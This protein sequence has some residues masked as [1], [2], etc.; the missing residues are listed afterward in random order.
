GVGDGARRQ[1]AAAQ[2]V[3]GRQRV[4]SP[5][6]LVLALLP[7]VAGCRRAPNG[8]AG[9]AP[10]PVR[11]V[12]VFQQAGIH[13]RHTN[14]QSARAFTAE[15]LGS[16]CAFLDYDGDGRLDLFLV[17]SSRLP[18]FPGKGPFYPALYRNVGG[19]KF[20]E[21]TGQAGLAIDC[22]GMGAAVADYDNDGDPD[23]LLTS[24][25]G[26]HLFRNDGGRFT[27]VTRQAGVTKPAWGTSA[28]W[29]DYDRDGWLDLFIGNYLQWSPES[30]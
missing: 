12:D 8:P 24:Y 1:I 28:A 2:R 20:R 26:S 3:P 27:E 19:G 4:L 10:A 21:V 11:F 30:N 6:A 22:Y 18:G 9:A 15:T 5:A 17:N 14:G 23:L 7:V 16:G 25:G 29:F 13:F